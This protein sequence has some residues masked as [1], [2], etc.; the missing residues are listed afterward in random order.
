MGTCNISTQNGGGLQAQALFD[1]MVLY[2]SPYVVV[3][4]QG[5]TN[6]YYAGSERIAS[7]IG[8]LCWREIA[9]DNWEIS[10]PESEALKLF[11][12]I[13]KNYP[14]GIGSDVSQKTL[15]VAYNDELDDYVQYNC[16]FVELPSVTILNSHDMLDNTMNCYDSYQNDA[17]VYYYHSDHLGSTSWV[18][19]EA[20]HEHQ[21]LAYLPYG[22]PL[23]NVLYDTILI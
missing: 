16:S 11:S 20:G 8:D 5:Y 10:L 19:D 3:T 15:N 4:P 23:L 13:G 9:T 6:H 21:F 2:P 22:E 1:D 7:R 18:T 14:F 17:P 12:D